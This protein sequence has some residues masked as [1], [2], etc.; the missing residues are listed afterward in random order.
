M[1]P[2]T[3][4]TASYSRC[5][6]NGSCIWGFPKD[7]QPSTTLNNHGRVC[8]K[9]IREDDRYVVSYMPFLSRLL[10]CHVNVDICFTV[11]V[12]MYLYKYLFKGPDRTLFNITSD[13]FH[14]ETVDYIDARYLSASEAA[15]RILEYNIS[16]KEPAVKVLSIHLPDQ[17]LSQMYRTNNSQSAATTLLC[18]FGRPRIPALETLLYTE[19]Y[20]KYCLYPISSDSSRTSAHIR[21][22]DLLEIPD[23]PFPQ[24][25]IQAQSRGEVVARIR[26]VPPRVGELFY[27]RALLLHKHT[28]SFE[29]LRSVGNTTYTTFQ[30]AA[31]ALG[32]FQNSNEAD[33]A[34]AEAIE[35]FASSHQLRF[36][37][38]Q[39][40]LNFPTNAIT[41]FDRHQ[42]QLMADYLD[43]Y[44]SAELA[45]D[46]AL[47]DLDRYLRTQGSRLADFGLPQPDRQTSLLQLEQ[48]HFASQYINLTE[49]YQDDEISLS[50][51]QLDAYYMVLE[52]FYTPISD[53]IKTCFFIE[54]KA[55][56]GKSFTANVL[57]NRLRSE[58]HI[59][60][61]VGSTAL[62]VTQYERGRTAHSAFGIPVTEVRFFFIKNLLSYYTLILALLFN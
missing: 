50:N 15:W 31:A 45:T 24:Q 5:N 21:P 43:Q 49:K 13:E 26:T 51:E 19:Y 18:Y 53:R 20:E 36:L 52:S 9:R 39:L 23:Q 37:F 17:H 8:Y 12:F 44:N 42:E 57:V 58:G 56:R 10:D 33:L 14:D 32:L 35:N 27:L 47:R 3:H 16:R 59:V 22:D 34:L 25:I 60:L 1:H 7:L 46:L 41:L 55:G 28:F 54:G 4:L 2:K 11:N 6:R 61:V 48:V 29:G 40:L 62:S 30:E 38:C